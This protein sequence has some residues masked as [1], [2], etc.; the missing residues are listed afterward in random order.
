MIRRKSVIVV[1]AVLLALSGQVIALA[2]ACPMES[3]AMPMT[4]MDSMNS[5]QS[6][7][8]LPM[9]G[10]D[11][12]MTPVGAEQGSTQVMD[13]QCD[14]ICSYCLFCLSI[15]QNEEGILNQFEDSAL[16]SDPSQFSLS[17]LPDNPFRPPI[18]A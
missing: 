9:A 10:H 4:G 13:C 8:S 17:S 11:M 18:T 12:L 3:M 2:A 14:Q 15:P 1:I 5:S 16:L 7:D 6:V